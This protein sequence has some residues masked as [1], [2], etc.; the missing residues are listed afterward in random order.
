MAVINLTNG[1]DNFIDLSNSGDTI[2]GLG[3][4]DQ[5]TGG[6]GDDTINGGPGNDILTGGL[7]SDTLSGGTGAD[8]FRDTMA[9]LNGDHIID[10][11]IGDRIEITD[12]TSANFAL[13]GNTITFGPGNADSVTVDGLGPGRLI[14]YAL[15]GGGFGLRLESDAHND[16]NGD[17]RSDVLWTDGNSVVD[18]LGASDGSFVRNYSASVKSLPAGW[19]VVGTGDFNADGSVDLLLRNTNGTIKDWLGGANGSLTDNSANSTHAVPTDWTVA[20]TGDFNGDGHSD[21]LWRNSSGTV[22]DWLGTANGDFTANWASFATSVPNAWQIV[23][24]GDFNGDG[25]DDILWRNTTTGTI[26]DF[27]ANETGGFTDNYANAAVQV[28]TAWSVIGT[29][30][31]NGDGLTDIL[32]RNGTTVTDWLG[33][34]TGGFTANWNNFHTSV[35]TSWNVAQTGDFNG[36]GIDDLLWRGSDGSI[37]DW[38]GTTAGSFTDNWAHAHTAVSTTWHVV[39]DAFLP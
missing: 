16:F 15:Q 35:P 4:N 10:F 11:S 21:I 9:G 23:G 24:T 8:T 31:F 32:W 28:P 17:G 5:I 37:T 13:N 25:R 27:L 12:L 26:T 38:L 6:S 30:D 33:T 29:G 22:T 36:D 14:S 19:S 39:G 34:A 20:G 7:G 18:W 1:P 3:G 2:N